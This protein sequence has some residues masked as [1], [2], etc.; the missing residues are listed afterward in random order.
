MRNPVKTDI[1]IIIPVINEQATVNQAIEQLRKQDFQGVVE[2][3]VVDGGRDHATLNAIEDREVVRQVS[4][5]GRGIQ[6][7]QGGLVAA[8]EVLLFLHCDT[9]LPE[10]GLKTV[11]EVMAG[12]N[13]KAGAF[14]L[15][16]DRKGVVWRIIEKTASLRS[17]I[18]R[19]PY[20]DQAIFIQRSFFVETGLYRN[21]P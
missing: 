11:A 3:V 21:I 15:S 8:G 12:R 19:I 13:V 7:N 9:V 17:R 14:D 18:T 16:I 1:S 10:N 20:G 6:M 4:P 2:I 5:P